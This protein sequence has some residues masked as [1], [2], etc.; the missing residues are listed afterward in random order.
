MIGII[1]DLISLGLRILCQHFLALEDIIF[2][3][4]FLEPL[5]DLVLG[6]CTLDD[7]EPVTARSL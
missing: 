4:F 1:T 2:F 7:L 5:I 3:E 6:L